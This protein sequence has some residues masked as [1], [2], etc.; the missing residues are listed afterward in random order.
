M[1]TILL[2][3]LTHA[4]VSCSSAD[5]EDVAFVRQDVISRDCLSVRE[6][7][8]VPIVCG[9]Y[10]ATSSLT[11]SLSSY[12]GNQFSRD[13]VG[14]SCSCLLGSKVKLVIPGSVIQ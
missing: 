11:C 10:C 9:N 14:R 12:S 6:P 8:P 4:L 7:P 3:L 13:V 1:R 5:G 2:A